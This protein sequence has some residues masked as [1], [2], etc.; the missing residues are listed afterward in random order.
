VSSSSTAHL[1]YTGLDTCLY[2]HQPDPAPP[3]LVD[4]QTSHVPALVV[5]ES[6]LW[7]LGC[8]FMDLA[9]WPQGR[10]MFSATDTSDNS[11]VMIK[12]TTRCVYNNV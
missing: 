2:H 10:Q 1:T 7:L 12:F 11:R 5:S 8:R 9:R 3:L 6:P 4:A